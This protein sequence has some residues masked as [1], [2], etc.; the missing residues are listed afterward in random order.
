MTLPVA[1][2]PDSATREATPRTWASLASVTQAA[3]M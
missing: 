3:Q 2:R 1:S